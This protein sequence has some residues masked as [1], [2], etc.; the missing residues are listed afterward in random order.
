[1]LALGPNYVFVISLT[2]PV[3]NMKK[4]PSCGKRR[5]YDAKQVSILLASGRTRPWRRE[6]AARNRQPQR[7]IASAKTFSL[8]S[9]HEACLRSG[10]LPSRRRLGWVLIDFIYVTALH[11]ILHLSTIT[12]ACGYCVI[13]F[14]S[15]FLDSPPS[16]KFRS[17]IAFRSF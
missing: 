8:P 5:G 12:S 15:S 17:L 2:S 3:Q 10:V 9:K 4:C 14:H 13:F 1:M 7:N 11:Y 16:S 6:R